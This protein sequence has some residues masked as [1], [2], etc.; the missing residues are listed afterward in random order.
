MSEVGCHQWN[1]LYLTQRELAHTNVWK[2]TQAGTPQGRKHRHT[3]ASTRNSNKLLSPVPFPESC[4]L[5]FQH[6]QEGYSRFVVVVLMRKIVEA[7]GG[8]TIFLQSHHQLVAQPSLDSRPPTPNSQRHV[9]SGFDNF[10]YLA[11]LPDHLFEKLRSEVPCVVADGSGY[12][13]R[14]QM[15]PRGVEGCSQTGNVLI[16][17]HKQ[18]G[19]GK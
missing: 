6:V 17:C 9:L 7:Q 14:N 16:L 4:S 10:P 15:A 1:G 5:P 2:T 11:L 12:R 8:Y 19:R 13:H 18:Q 3:L